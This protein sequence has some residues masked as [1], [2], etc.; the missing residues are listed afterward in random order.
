MSDAPPRL[1]PLSVW[2][3]PVR[4]FHWSLLAAVLVAGISGFLLPPAWLNL[5]LIGGT[6]VLVLLLFRLVWGFTGSSFSRFSSF[7]FSPGT[8][9]AYARALVK[10]S[11]PHHDGHNPVGALMIFALLLV[12][13]VLAVTGV[14]V[15]GGAE[16]Q[17]PLRAVL[18]YATG[19]ATREVHEIVAYVLLALI[20][21]HIFGVV[22]ESRRAKV[23]LPLAMV[24]GRK[25]STSQVPIRPPSLPGFF[26]GA[27][28]LTVV[29][30]GSA[31]LLWR[32]PA[33]GIP[34]ETPDALY[35]K[36]CGDCHI[37]FH[38]SLRGRAAWAAIMG[39][40]SDHFGED[41]S[42]GG[43]V[44]ANLSDYLQ[45]NAG[46][47]FDTRAANVFRAAAPLRITETPF[48]TRRHAGIAEE[49]FKAPKVGT[50]SNCEACHGDAR[51]GCSCPR[52]S[53]YQRSRQ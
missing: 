15:L 48:W 22:I 17:G 39:D 35:V 27:M 24:T 18:S 7:T 25:P 1:P 10:G 9:A 6:A 5:H 38:P 32:M 47:R 45:L 29:I 3:L 14:I 36:E 21:G 11:A 33:Q 4:L 2:D 49:V 51:Q 30:G 40:L 28:V 31:L 44:T 16:K 46:E 42:L 19:S 13:A 20:A 43:D 26:A 52:R 41:A 34:S 50:K 23:N 8:M 12:L 53:R 37:P